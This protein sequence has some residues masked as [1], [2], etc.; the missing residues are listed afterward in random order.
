[1]ATTVIFIHN[2]KQ[3][4]TVSERDVQACLFRAGQLLFLAP[5]SRQYKFLAPSSTQNDFL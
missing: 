4:E 2:L 5:P 3:C 1:M